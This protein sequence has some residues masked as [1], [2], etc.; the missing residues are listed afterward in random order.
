MSPTPKRPRVSVDVH[1]ELRRR[2]RLAAAKRDLTL[3]QYVLQAIEE[4]IEEDLGPAGAEE[5]FLSAK[6]DPVLAEIWRN[7]RDARYDDCRRGD[8]V[9]VRFVFS[10]ESGVKL[11]PALVVS[12][13]AY[14][15]SR[16]EAVVAAITSNVRRQLPGDHR[17]AHWK[18]AGLLFPSL[19][20]G[21]LRT[22]KQGMIQRKLGTLRAA[23]ARAVDASLRAALGL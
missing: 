18:E 12:S 15:R 3:R 19:V 4:R 20:T 7:R 11:R 14:Q 6:T 9:L 22:V 5:S 8:V 21:V 2:L 10:D 16:E 1:P 13:D 17:L 23:D